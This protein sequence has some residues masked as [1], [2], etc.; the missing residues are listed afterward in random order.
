MNKLPN[1]FW[2]SSA[3]GH[4]T[5]LPL[6][7]VG[8]QF[9]LDVGQMGL[10]FAGF[11]G[12]QVLAAPGIAHLCDT[13]GKEKV[14]VGGTFSLAVAMGSLPFLTNGLDATV[15]AVFGL[16]G[17]GQ[18]VYGSAPNALVSDL[19]TTE[20]RAQAL[21]MLRTSNDLGFLLGASVTGMFADCFS[22]EMALF[23]LSAILLGNL[24]IFH[25]AQRLKGG[26]PSF[27]RG[28]GGGG[29]KTGGGAGGGPTG[30]G[31]GSGNSPSSSPRTGG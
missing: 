18:A 28:G 9:N 2:V 14:L 27:G 16:W 17:V 13:L 24:G 19:V 29:S 12:V 31:G 22:P 11:A 7:L 20:Q 23:S 25:R 10:V 21:S 30:A 8:P 3:G 4:A 15:V 5:I 6:I 26:Y 1:R